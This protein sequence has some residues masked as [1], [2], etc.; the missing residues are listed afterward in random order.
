MNLCIILDILMIDTDG[1]SPLFL[2]P[3]PPDRMSSPSNC[4]SSRRSGSNA[5]G[6]DYFRHFYD[7]NQGTMRRLTE[8]K[9]CRCATELLSSS[10]E[11][12]DEEWH[13]LLANGS[14][15][16]HIPEKGKF[17]RELVETF[18]PLGDG[19]NRLGWFCGIFTP[20]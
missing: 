12:L 18:C 8:L 11:R 14:R 15:F 16:C 3:D 17:G 9:S 7:V 5:D 2:L 13:R 10:T 20:W 19:H 6:G 4:T 1:Y